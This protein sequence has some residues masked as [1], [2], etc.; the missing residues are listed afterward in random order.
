MQDVWP[1]LKDNQDR[2]R[3][4][5]LYLVQKFLFVKIFSTALMLQ[6]MAIKF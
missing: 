1:V 2:E 4:N 3:N 5:I 6:I